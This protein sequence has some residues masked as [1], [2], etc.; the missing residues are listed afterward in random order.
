M[1]QEQ[2]QRAGLDPRSF[3]MLGC[4]ACFT[5]GA[6][7]VRLMS[8]TLSVSEI[9]FWRSAVMTAGLA[10]W[11][12]SR[13]YSFRSPAPRW[14]ALRCLFGIISMFCWFTV[15]AR[16]P[17]ATAS[18]LMYTSPLFIAGATLVAAVLARR[19]APWKL[20]LPILSGF[21]GLVLALSPRLEATPDPAWLIGLSAGFFS[22]MASLSIRTA[23]AQGEQTW[24]TVFYFAFTSALAAGAAQFVTEGGFSALSAHSVFLIAGLVLTSLGMQLCF[25][26]SFSSRSILLTAVLQYTT[27]A[28]L[29]V[30]GFLFF[31]EQAGAG[32]LT[33]IALIA[34]SGIASTVLMR[35]KR[36]AAAQRP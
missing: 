6:V 2:E 1:Q 17:M 32:Q 4:A 9:I 25:T 36:R 30:A 23:A 16:L 21:A 28:M 8:G 34:L 10:A 19:S 33:G 12:L 31:G 24:R 22:A 13:G 3:W 11:A 35:A 29:A 7:F 14:T 5:A 26:E 18:A 20:T 15:I 27:I